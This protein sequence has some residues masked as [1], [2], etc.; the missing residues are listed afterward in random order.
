HRS[1]ALDAPDV[2]QKLVDALRAFRREQAQ[3][4]AIPAFR[5]FT[6][7]ALYTLAHERPRTEAELLTIS[8]VSRSLARK[9]GAQLL[10]IVRA[11]A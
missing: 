2:P 1:R 5:V 8:G 4:R 6:D 3:A 9:Y 11:D 7:R 10:A